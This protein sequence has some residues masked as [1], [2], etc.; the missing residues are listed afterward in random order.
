MS[1]IRGRQPIG[2]NQPP[3]GGSLYPF[4]NPSDDIK[5]LLGDFFISFDDLEDN[6]VYPLRIKWLYG[7]GSNSVSPISG[8]PVPAHAQDIIVVDA[9]NLVVFDSTTAT[10]FK[11]DDWDSRLT[12]VEWESDS[13]VCRCT[14][15]YE[16]T[17]ADI[18]DGNDI[19]Y[20]NYIE[21][22]N[23]ELQADTWYK[24][25]KRVTSFVVGLN[26][27]AKNKVIFREGYNI[28][29]NAGGGV[30]L[31]TAALPVFVQTKTLTEGTRLSNQITLDATPGSGLGVYTGCDNITTTVK[32]L[33][34]QVG[35]SHQ[36]FLLDSEACIRNQRPVGVVN[37]VNREVAYGDFYLNPTQSAA[38]L[39]LSNDCT[40]CCACEYFARTY[41]GL[42]RQWFLY[43]DVAQAAETA[44]D[45]YAKNI[46]RW[47]IQKQIREAD[48]IRI[49]IS[50]D[51]N[52]KLRYGVALCNSSKCCLQNVR[53]YFTFLQYVDGQLQ[54]PSKPLFNCPPTL[55]D[56]PAQ[57]E[58]IE[59]GLPEVLDDYG[60]VIRFTVDYADPQDVITISGKHCFPDCKDVADG[61]L[62]TMVHVAVTWSGSSIDP[63]SGVDCN[64]ALVS[65]D[66][67]PT[68]VKSVWGDVAI[69]G[70][71]TTF[72]TQK[73]S[74]L[75]MVDKTNPF[76]YQCECD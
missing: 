20:D 43:R 53:F 46:D 67:F 44:R 18:A 41:Q 48:N 55:I 19:T 2:I 65:Y 69:S 4:V 10:S 26:S 49:R 42:K 59:T 16:W 30:P 63:G 29:L 51:G 58:G 74:S 25:P 8:Y 71:E 21:P 14:F 62:K 23:S 61:A 72:Y 9:N 7:F 60:R 57:C 36:N 3:G 33:N 15:H 35:N 6:V 31:L 75:Y 76:C 47:N 22:T 52:C 64:Y 27:I 1:N 68:D 12:I 37:Y 73:A 39:K 66:S 56:G 11:T 17:A 50:V 34:G 70:V 5:Y 28:G 54:T 24:M 40:C 32:K 13:V 38:A 45:N